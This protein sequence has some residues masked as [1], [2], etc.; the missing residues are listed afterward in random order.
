MHSEAPAMAARPITGTTLEIDLTSPAQLE[1]TN[2]VRRFGSRTVL[3]GADLRVPAGTIAWL[4]GPNGSG[5]TTL[6]RIAAGIVVPD[7]GAVAI[8]GLDP[9]RDRR[10]CHR[11]LGY[12]SAG[13]RALYGRLTV[14]QNLEFWAAVALVEP[15][16]RPELID[17]SLSRFELGDLATSRVDRLSTGQRQRVRLA[18]TFLHEPTLVLLD[19][20]HNS[21][22]EHALLLLD[23]AL[24]AL[25]GRGGSALW[26]SPAPTAALRADAA[27]RLQD[28]RVVTA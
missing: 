5:K 13:D 28:G 2:I 23:A 12:L 3:T 8:T 25:A 14:A 20:P 6:L 15:R 1:L 24:N 7:S 4:G 26:C 22:D 17:A 10:A 18:M 9:A 16:R 19:E 27:Y 21:L 11:R